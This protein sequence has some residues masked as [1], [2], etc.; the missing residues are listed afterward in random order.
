MTVNGH[1]LMIDQDA[2]Y[3]V[4][5]R[6]SG[7]VPANAVLAMT[8]PT[9]TTYVDGSLVCSAGSCQV[10]AD[11]VQW[12]GVVAPEQPINLAFAVRVTTPLPDRTPLTSIATLDDGFGNRIEEKITFLVRRSDL[13]TTMI[14]LRPP[15]LEP[16]QTALVVL[17]VRNQGPM[18]TNATVHHTAPQG[19]LVVGDSLSCSAGSCTLTD[20]ALTWQGPMLAR[21]VVRVSYLVQVPPTAEYGTEY[22]FVL[23]VSDIDWGDNFTSSATLRVARIAHLPFIY[24]PRWT[25]SLLLPLIAME[26]AE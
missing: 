19:V 2:R 18:A 1:E 9:L 14:E 10:V 17:H 15:N 8:I 21:S 25:G 20:S 12:S 23:E 11:Q 16:G 5:L 7:L 3:E 26:V 22:A 6:N 13:S 4:T 24:M